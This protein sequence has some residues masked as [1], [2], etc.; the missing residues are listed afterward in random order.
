MIERVALQSVS[1][2]VRCAPRAA[3]TPIAMARSMGFLSKFFGPSRE[4]LPTPVRDLGSFRAEVLESELPV[5][6]D[7]WSE[8]C[9]PCRQLVPVLKSVATRHE[10]RVRVAE[11]SA[12]SDPE[13][14]RQLGVR[15]TPTLLI[16]EGGQELGRVTGFRP[17][18]WFDEMIEAE[19]PQTEEDSP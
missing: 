3:G 7:V 13:L 12:D 1:S 5:I 16:F 11:I 8:S 10:G 2:R 15:A 6:V 18:G 19:F 4:V 9:A 17:G 14:L